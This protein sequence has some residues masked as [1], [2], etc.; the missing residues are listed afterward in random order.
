[1]DCSGEYDVQ[2][3][4]LDHHRLCEE[5]AHCKADKEF[6][7]SLW[8]QLQKESP[9]MTA[10]VDMVT[11]RISVNGEFKDSVGRTWIGECSMDSK[12]LLN[13]KLS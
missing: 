13:L 8:K 12:T 2:A 6:V 1:M 9:D 5:L 4:K 7:W 11:T 3:L 10:A